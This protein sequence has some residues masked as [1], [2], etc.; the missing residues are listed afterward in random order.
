MCQKQSQQDANKHEAEDK[1]N[2]G[3]YP[4]ALC[5]KSLAGLLSTTRQGAA[6]KYESKSCHLLVRS[7]TEIIS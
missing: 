3:L 6:V 5:A 4:E 1:R 2:L 7:I